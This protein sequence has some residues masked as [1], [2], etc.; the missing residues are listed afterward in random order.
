MAALVKE[1]LDDCLTFDWPHYVSHDWDNIP[2]V[3][4]RF[5]V[6]L[7]KYMEGVTAIVKTH[8]KEERTAMLRKDIEQRLKTLNDTI[9]TNEDKH[10]MSTAS[11][12]ESLST[13]ASFSQLIQDELR[14]FETS[15]CYQKSLKRSDISEEH[16]ML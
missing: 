9:T 6:Q 15:S 13:N 1:K 11:I 16:L 2:P 10:S 12:H 8:T 4:P 3:V 5:I 7:S 14:S